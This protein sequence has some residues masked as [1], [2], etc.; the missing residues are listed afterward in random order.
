MRYN[1]F[2]YVR[3]L[4]VDNPRVQFYVVVC[5]P[6]IPRLRIRNAYYIARLEIVPSLTRNFRCH[7]SH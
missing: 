6:L 5:R 1:L 4:L 2:A 7:L 3:A